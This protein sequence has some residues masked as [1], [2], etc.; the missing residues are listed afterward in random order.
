[1][2]ANTDFRTYAGFTKEEAE[3]KFLKDQRESAY[4]D[5]HSYSGCIGV[6]PFG[7][8]WVL[9]AKLPFLNG[10]PALSDTEA[11]EYI[12][13]N[14]EKWEKAMGVPFTRIE[15]GDIPEETHG[16]VIGGWCSS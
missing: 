8:D 4:E 15:E 6:M 11:M 7:I 16:F 10:I 2:G 3:E 13:E 12:S 14:H 9:K 1:M 5:G